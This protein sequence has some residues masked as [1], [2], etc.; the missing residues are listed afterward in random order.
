MDDL[1]NQVEKGP[2]KPNAAKEQ[3]MEQH[4]IAA[5]ELSKKEAARKQRDKLIKE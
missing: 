3:R 2:K 4:E 1:I 5:D